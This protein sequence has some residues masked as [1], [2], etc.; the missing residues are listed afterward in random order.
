[1]TCTVVRNDED[2]YSLRPAGG[3]LP[4]GGRHAGFT[5]GREECLAHL[6]T[7]RTDMRPRSLRDRTA[8]R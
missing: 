3:G 7:V 5:G 4:P 1:V 6:G 8:P 2:R